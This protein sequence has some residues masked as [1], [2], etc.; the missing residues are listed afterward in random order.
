MEK[1]HTPA[2]ATESDIQKWESFFNLAIPADLK[3]LL[4]DA[5]GPSLFDASI[6]KELQILSTQEAIEYVAAYEFNDYCDNATPVAMDGCGNFVVFKTI[7]GETENLYAMAASN[8]G[9]EDAVC[10][11]ASLT[12]VIDM[13]QSIESV[14]N[15]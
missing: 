2:A 14:L 4:L 8:L 6:D 7:S 13:Q 5:N 10:L 15:R 11:A 9:W 3:A 12:T 1:H